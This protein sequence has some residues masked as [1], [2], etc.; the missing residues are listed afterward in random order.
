LGELYSEIVDKCPSVLAEGDPD[1]IKAI[2]D[3]LGG[4]YKDLVKQCPSILSDGRASEIKAIKDM[5]GAD[6][7][8]FGGGSLLQNATSSRSLVCYLFMIALAKGLCKKRIMLSNGFGPI[9]DDLISEKAWLGLVSLALSCFDHISARD[10][11]SQNALSK[12]SKNKKVYLLPDLTIPN[13]L[14]IN[15]RLNFAD[16]DSKNEIKDKPYFVFCPHAQSLKAQG[17]SEEM[18]ALSLKSLARIFDARI[19][20]AVLNKKQ[21]LGLAISITKMIEN[22]DIVLS[23]SAYALARCFADSEF[24]ISQRYHGTLLSTC[25]MTPTVAVSSD[26]KMLGLCRDLF[27]EPPHSASI[28]K[29]A[30]LLLKAIMKALNTESERK[31]NTISALEK[32]GR[33]V[34]EFDWF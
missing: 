21:D 30:A 33:I 19:R 3:A 13:L 14:K 4:L 29:D 6:L 12:L 18:V 1:E 2:K 11:L 22:S 5:L 27:L 34:E 17:V 28:L 26:P 20:I 31:K 10:T 16:K 24:V 25:A 7:F 8:I 23:D 32:Y 15:H 9:K